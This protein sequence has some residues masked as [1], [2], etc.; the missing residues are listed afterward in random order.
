MGTV[1]GGKSYIPAVLEYS[2]SGVSGSTEY[3]LE[4]DV[5]SSGSYILNLKPAAPKPLIPIIRAPSPTK[6]SP[7]KPYNALP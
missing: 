4:L 3:S 6:H 7:A 2:S 5:A 1:R